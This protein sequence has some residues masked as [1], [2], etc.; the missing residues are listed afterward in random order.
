MKAYMCEP[1]DCSESVDLVFAD[2]RS[3]ARQI[4]Q[5]RGESCNECEFIE[6]RAIRVPQA[7]KYEGMTVTAEI[8]RDIGWHDF[9]ATCDTC[10]KCGM[11]D[12]QDGTNK[13]EWDICPDCV[14]CGE[15]G[16]TCA[17]N[18]AVNRFMEEA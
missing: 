1:Y 11:S 18:N 12:W 9:T 5:G 15:C 2:N 7:D 14:Q 17:E 4:A 6:I 16:C 3:Q 10:G 13:T 8:W